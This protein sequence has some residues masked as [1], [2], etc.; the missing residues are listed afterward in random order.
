[1]SEQAL[2]REWLAVY[3]YVI[4]PALLALTGAVW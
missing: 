4:V 1:M 2:Q 3:F